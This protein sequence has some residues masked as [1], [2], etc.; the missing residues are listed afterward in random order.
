MV[1]AKPG[2]FKMGHCV[3]LVRGLYFFVFLKRAVCGW[4]LSRSI[5]ENKFGKS[6]S[7]LSCEASV[8][9]FKGIRSYCLGVVSFGMYVWDCYG[10]VTGPLF[11]KCPMLEW[12]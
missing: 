9:C 10:L 11:L 4:R 6:L 7:R 8:L 1:F 5:P 12:R 2:D 3:C